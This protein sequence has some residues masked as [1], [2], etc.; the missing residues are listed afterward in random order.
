MNFLRNH[1]YDIGIIIG[2]SIFSY[3]IITKDSMSDISLVLWLSFVSLFIHQFEEYRFPGNFPGVF[4]TVIF[5]SELPDRYPI[6]SDTSLV[7]NVFLGWTSYLL[8]ALFGEKYIWLGM[9]TVL[10]SAAN[11]V[12]HVIVV[13]IKGK[14]FYNP[15]MLTSLTLFLPVTI[16]FFYLT[17]HN[18]LA[19]ATDYI[20]GILLGFILNYF[21]LIKTI[22]WMKNKKTQYVFPPRCARITNF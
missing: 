1:W 6:N 19:S 18:N 8:A 4:N 16:Y 20:I 14:R 5:N 7:V 10:I 22:Q 13:N 17:A 9:A 2:L 21:G 11:I 3:I 15:G 12:A